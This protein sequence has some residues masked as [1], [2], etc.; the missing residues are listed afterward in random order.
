LLLGRA[1]GSAGEHLAAAYIASQLERLGLRPFPAAGDFLLPIPLK[2][3]RIGAATNVVLSRNGADLTFRNEADFVVNLGG[4]DAFHDFGGGV[5]FAGP[6][7]MAAARLRRHGDFRGRVIALTAQPREAPPL[8]PALVAGGAAGVVVLA[9]DTAY[10]QLIVRSRGDSRFFLDADVQDPVAQPNLPVLVAGPGLTA[11]LLAGAP[12]TRELIEG[13]STVAVLDL[14]RELRAHIAIDV[15]AVQAANVGGLLPGADPARRDQL[16]VYT[17]HYDHLGVSAPDQR[18]DTIYNG[19]SDDAA[20]V[21]MLLAIAEALRASPPPVSVAFLFFTGEER[22]L[23]GSAFL[24]ARPPFPLPNVRGL[25]NLDAGAPP[26]PPLTWRL[27][28]GNASPLGKLA[29]QV[30]AQAGW[31]ATSGD[32]SP[33]SDYWPFLARGVPAIFIIPGGEWEHV[34]PEQQKALNERWNHYHEPADEWNRE[35]P[36]SGLERYA[37]LAL[38]VG[39]ALT[40]RVAGRTDRQRCNRGRAPRPAPASRPGN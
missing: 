34:T 30:A 3:A 2:A 12:L 4:R 33:N 17:A 31:K 40:R 19:F 25:I 21:G 16:V 35:F 7:A 23:L 22:G 27:A 20:G 1:T 38:R 18:G 28:G 5:I 15:R 37:D 24:A 6:P 26:A 32:A 8:V 29:E 13:D 9:P 11:A 10:Y 39:L 36:L 14:G